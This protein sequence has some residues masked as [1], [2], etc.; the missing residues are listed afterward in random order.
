VHYEMINPSILLGDLPLDEQLERVRA[1]GFTEIELW[2]PF[3]TATP[4]REEMRGFLATIDASGLAL[5]GLNVYEGGMAEGNRGIACWPHR[6][7]ELAAAIAASIEIGIATGCR[8]FNVL[9]GTIDPTEDRAVQDARAAVNTAR[10]ADA[11]AGIGGVVTIEQLSHIPAYGLRTGSDVIAAID[12]AIA[13]SGADNIRMQVD[14]FHMA[15][16]GDDIP[17]FFDAYWERIAH[18]QVADAPGRGGPGTGSV[19]IDEYLERL[20]SNGYTG[21]FALEYSAVDAVSGDPFGWL[22]V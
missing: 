5:R 15:M 2:W 1:A 10:A 21:R 16:I 8:L 22:R 18:V 17:A 9:H 7:A 3:A 19:P 6:E 4:S 12:R 11:L 14:L 20:R 13:V